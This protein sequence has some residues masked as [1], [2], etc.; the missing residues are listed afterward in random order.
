LPNWFLSSVAHKDNE[1][2]TYRVDIE[3]GDVRRPYRRL[4]FSWKGIPIPRARQDP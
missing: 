3:H 4:R 2:G 1:K